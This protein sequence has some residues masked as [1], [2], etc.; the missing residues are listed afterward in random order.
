MRAGEQLPDRHAAVC[1]EHCLVCPC[2]RVMQRGALTDPGEDPLSGWQVTSTTLRT[3]STSDETPSDG[4]VQAIKDGQVADW[5][6]LERILHDALYMQVWTCRCCPLRQPDT[7]RMHHA[8]SALLLTSSLIRTA[9]DAL[10]VP[11]AAC[12]W[13]GRW[14]RRAIC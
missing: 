1:G 4:G 2:L 9:A 14:A 11:H 7:F 10:T 12:S 13:V 5:A 6:A 3:A 8:V